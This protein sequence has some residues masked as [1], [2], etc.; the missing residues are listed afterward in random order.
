[1]DT[2]C[3]HGWVEDREGYRKL[4]TSEESSSSKRRVRRWFVLKRVKK[5]K[6]HGSCACFVPPGPRRRVVLRRPRTSERAERG[7]G[8][9]EIA[10]TATTPKT[11]RLGRS[12][13]R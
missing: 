11:A 3:A 1:M 12:A 7:Q 10:R 5:V 9:L 2:F 4:I 6:K 8:V 13:F